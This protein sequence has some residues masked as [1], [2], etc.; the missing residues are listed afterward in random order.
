MRTCGAIPEQAASGSG[1]IGV[2]ELIGNSLTRG[3]E[4]T[5]EEVCR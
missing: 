4:T 1:V 5:F 3:P 2:K